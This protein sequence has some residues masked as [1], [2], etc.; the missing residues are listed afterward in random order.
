MNLDKPLSN[1]LL[2]M[3]F[4]AVVGTVI[5]GVIWLYL[6]IANVGVTL[7]WHVIPEHLNVHGY[8]LIVCLIGG[9]VVGLF[10]KKYGP[11]PQSMQD[12]VSEVRRRR[13]F[14]YANMPL[15]LAGSLLPLL[16]GGAVGPEAGLVSLLLGFCFWTKDQFA[17]QRLLMLRLIEEDPDGPRGYVFGEMVRGLLLPASKIYFP[18]DV[19]PWKKSEAISAGVVA[20]VSAL[21]VY[22]VLN[23]LFG[24]GLSVPHLEVTHISTAGHFAAILLIAVGFGAGYLYLLGHKFAKFVFSFL[25]DRNMDIINAILGGLILGLIGTAIP[26]SMFSGG[27]MIQSMQYEYLK[28]TPFLLILIGIM[29]LFLTSICIESGWRG[30]QLFPMLFSGLSIGYGFAQL[31]SISELYAVVLVTTALIATVFQQPLGAIVLSAIVLPTEYVGWMIVAGFVAGC[32]P[33]P[34][35]IRLNPENTGFI[36]KIATHARNFRGIEQKR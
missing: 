4:A 6:K 7:I 32:I 33:Q 34:E 31:L 9:L 27:N 36:D 30:G 21:I 15:I 17:M 14:S 11:Y 23:A 26:M 16:F 5:A 35:A 2:F 13:R 12:A 28:Y 3:S 8:T 19:L 1:G 24:R 18:K 29:K 25:Q 22:E 20:G 10:H